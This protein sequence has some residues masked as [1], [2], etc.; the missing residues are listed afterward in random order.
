[1]SGLHDRQHAAWFGWGGWNDN[2]FYGADTFAPFEW[3]PELGIQA[4]VGWQ[5]WR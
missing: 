4:C 1:M 5:A 2:A 3:S